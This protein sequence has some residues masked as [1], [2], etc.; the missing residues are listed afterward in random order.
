MAISVGIKFRA[1]IRGL[2]RATGFC[3]AVRKHLRTV[4][5]IES[6]GDRPEVRGY[7]R[8]HPNPLHQE[9]EFQFGR[10]WPVRSGERKTPPGSAEDRRSCTLSSGRGGWGE[11]ERSESSTFCLR[12]APMTLRFVRRLAF[13]T[14]RRYASRSRYSLRGWASALLN[15]APAQPDVM[16]S[17]LSLCR[18]RDTYTGGLAFQVFRPVN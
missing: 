5:Q 6:G 8:P 10:A 16:C 7:V 17:C 11:G 15:P 4:P 12:Y 9:R 13:E 1:A 18:R 14:S 2:A 3:L